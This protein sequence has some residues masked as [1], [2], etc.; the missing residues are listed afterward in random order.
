M[1]PVEKGSPAKTE[2]KPDEKPESKLGNPAAGKAQEDPD[3]WLA[4]CR[5]HSQSL[6]SEKG[7]GGGQNSGPP[8]G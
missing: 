1:P 8:G 6:V 2:H 4:E 7:T 3:M 5:P